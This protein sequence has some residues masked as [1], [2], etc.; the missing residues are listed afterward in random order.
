MLEKKILLGELKHLSLVETVNKL[1]SFLSN[2][3]KNGSLTLRPATTVITGSRQLK[4]APNMSIFP[5]L[6][7]TGSIDKLRPAKYK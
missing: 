4:I 5:S 3:I 1:T 7:S 2:G 6:G